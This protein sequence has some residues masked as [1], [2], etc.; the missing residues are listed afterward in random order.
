MEGCKKFLTRI[1]GGKGR[2]KKERGFRYFPNKYWKVSQRQ[3]SKA[4][5]EKIC[6]GEKHISLSRPLYLFPR[7]AVTDCQSWWLKTTVAEA[8]NPKS[9]CLQACTSSKH[10]RGEFPLVSLT[11]GGFIFTWTPSF[12]VSYKDTCH[13]IKAPLDSLEKSHLEHYT[14][15]DPFSK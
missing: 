4:K 14:S 10:S 8:K 7:T 6:P 2:E 12:C 1:E 9:R 3:L 11:S 5:P 13:W 15:D